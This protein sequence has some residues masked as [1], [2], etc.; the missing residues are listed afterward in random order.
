MEKDSKTGHWKMFDF[1]KEAKRR[2]KKL[3]ETDSNSKS[4]VTIELTKGSKGLGFSIA[5]GVGNEHIPGDT[6]IYVTKIMENGAAHSDGRLVVG[7][8][9]IS[10]NGKSFDPIT[11]EDAVFILKSSTGRVVIT[12]LKNCSSPDSPSY[13]SRLHTHTAYQPQVQAQTQTC[14]NNGNALLVNSNSNDE[15]P[16]QQ[17]TS[18]TD[19]TT[20][21]L[22]SFENITRE[23]RTVHLV[24]GAN[25]LGFNIVGGE[26][27][28]GIF[29][30][31]LLAGG[32]ADLSGEL[33]KGDQIISVNDIDLREATHKTAAFALKGSPSN[34]KLVV[35][36]QP[37][38]Y[39]KF[40]AK[41]H[42][43]REHA[44]INT[45]G[46]LKTSQKKSLYVRSLFDYDPSRDSGLPSRG[47]PFK[48]GDI[49]HVI[50]ASDDEWWQARKLLL[51]GEESEFGIIPS[52]KRVEKRERAR[53]KY[54]KFQDKSN[55]K[56]DRLNT[57][58]RKKNF[59]FSRKFPFMK[60]REYDKNHDV[61]GI[62]E[63]DRSPT[64][65]TIY[66]ENE[67]NHSREEIYSYES[68]IKQEINYA[69]PVIILGSLKDRINDDLISEYPERF[70]SCVS[71][72]TR[73]K[74][75]CEIDG[76]DYHFVTSREQMEKDIQNHLFI[77]AGQYNDNLYGT[78]VASVREVAES[79]KH[80]ILD[81]SG[82]AI[83][84]L[85]AAGLSPIVIFIK[86]KSIES[87]M[88]MIKRIP[89]DQA[90]KLFERANK[91]EQEFTE[92]FTAIVTGDTP[93]EIYAKVKL[94]IHA[95]AGPIIWVRSKERIF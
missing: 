86:M 72:T 93:E 44:M 65:D 73:K 27:N 84:R 41:I 82:N 87:I 75:D 89:E 53:L 63:I 90:R 25:G 10:V 43:N 13:N 37:E 9:L 94:V 34:V 7:D 12:V 24:K 28:A 77:E 17:E 33:K 35:Q 46:T 42:N 76:Q 8:K 36:Y 67:A 39:N 31:F 81:V 61:S 70:C 15:S 62:D 11:H 45:S 66:P 1:S 49:I 51:D 18:V 58:D 38:D 3:S 85:Q 30:S 80:S 48:F 19:F 2:K 91:L 88:E 14:E 78:S 26:D 74:R 69:R 64:K 32:P 50:N 20:S 22:E 68:V 71:H 54:V 57:I 52:K 23:P 60:S 21:K 6:G 79:G 83:K 47:L 56:N 5:G 59:S 92:Y 4:I 55:S 16:F 40:E 29:I 95:N